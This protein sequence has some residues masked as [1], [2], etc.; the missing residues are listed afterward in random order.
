MRQGETDFTKALKRGLRR[1][2]TTPR[3]SPW[4]LE[5]YNLAP[6]ED[7]LEPHETLVSLGA[8]GVSWGGEG[9]Y[10]PTITTRDITI[11]VTDYVDDTEL[12]TV[13]VSLDGVAKGT[14]DSNGELVIAGVGI[15]GHELTLTKSGYENS[16]T[17]DIFNDYINVI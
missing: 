14:T 17:D 6:A 8:S 2:E 15:G 9:Q 10:S 4:L 3:N 5:C 11:R 1:F 7:G 13:S 12:Q 16:A